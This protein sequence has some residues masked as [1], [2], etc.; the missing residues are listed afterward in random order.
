[1]DSIMEIF[2]SYSIDIVTTAMTVIITIVSVII[3]SKEF[4]RKFT[5]INKEN[6]EL[7]KI[8]YNIVV[9][10]DKANINS[11]KDIE[12]TQSYSLKQDTLLELSEKRNVDKF[13]K[14]LSFSLAVIMSVTGT[15][16]LFIGIAL[17]L[18]FETKIGWITTSS[19]VIIEIVA[20]VYFWLVNK[21]MKEVKE[22]SQQLENTKNQI[23]A[24]ELV[25]KIEDSKTKDSVYVEMIKA[26]I[27]K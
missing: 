4:F 16:I 22:N 13:F 26:L 8:T 15:I 11:E 7:Q 14:K 21:T 23:T 5:K 18:F 20:S 9:E 1:M 2:A 3:T 6:I 10:N 27:A 17:S 24:M 19:G 25:E 12:L